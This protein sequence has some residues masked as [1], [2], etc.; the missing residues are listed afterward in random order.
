M[1]TQKALTC[2]HRSNHSEHVPCA[3]EHANKHTHASP[4]SNHT[5]HAPCAQEH[6]NNHTHASPC[7]NHTEHT[8]KTHTPTHACIASQQS[9]R[10]QDL[11]KPRQTTQHMHASPRSNHTEHAPSAQQH[12]TSTRMHR[13]AA[14]NVRMCLVKAQTYTPTNACIASQQSQ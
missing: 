1:N 4:R 10:A 6:T 3:Q 13:L 8:I 12:T 5:D 7:S 2:M 14:I 9:Q 11:C